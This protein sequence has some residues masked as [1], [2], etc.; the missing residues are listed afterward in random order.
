MVQLV[1]VFHDMIQDLPSGLN[2]KTKV[3]MYNL[4]V[5]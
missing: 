5:L 1:E 3:S 4:L 2:T